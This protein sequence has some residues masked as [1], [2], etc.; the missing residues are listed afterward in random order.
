[1]FKKTCRN[2]VQNS[3]KLSGIVLEVFCFPRTASAILNI[4]SYLKA[5]FPF[6]S[7]CLFMEFRDK[8]KISD[9]ILQLHLLQLIL[10]RKCSAYKL[11]RFC[12][13]SL[14]LISQNGKIIKK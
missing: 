9:L 12:S 6:F 7:V 11:S 5:C 2:L 14:R 10:A 13:L 8:I 3:V 1:M 4:F